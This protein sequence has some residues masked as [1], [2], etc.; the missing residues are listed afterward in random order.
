[1]TPRRSQGVWVDVNFCSRLFLVLKYLNCH[2][3]CYCWPRWDMGQVRTLSPSFNSN[4]SMSDIR[5]HSSLVLKGCYSEVLYLQTTV[6]RELAQKKR[7][8]WVVS[9]S[10]SWPV[11]GRDC[12]KFDTL[13]W[14]CISLSH[15]GCDALTLWWVLSVSLLIPS[16]WHH[17]IPSAIR[18]HILWK[19][20]NTSEIEQNRAKAARA[21]REML[22]LKMEALCFLIYVTPFNHGGYLL[23]FPPTNDKFRCLEEKNGDLTPLWNRPKAPSG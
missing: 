19:C 9:P 18:W 10:A 1:M 2:D 3:L 12:V 17:P 21:D 6:V 22:L 13:S 5:C 11:L 23:V 4:P 14:A 20:Q 15:R 16:I 7:G 8:H